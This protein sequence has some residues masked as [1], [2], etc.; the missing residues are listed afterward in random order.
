MPDGPFKSMT[1]DRDSERPF[2][3]NKCA[4]L[5]ECERCG[6]CIPIGAWPFCNGQP[7][8]HER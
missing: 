4:I 2:T 8:D 7:D 5:V 1:R 6:H 3:R